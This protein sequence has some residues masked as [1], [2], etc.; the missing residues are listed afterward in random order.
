MA[1]TIL[2]NTLIRCISYI[3]KSEFILRMVK[4]QS[5]LFTR[6]FERI[7]YSHPND[8]HNH[9]Y[10]RRLRDAYSSIEIIQGMPDLTKHALLDPSEN[11]LVIIEDQIVEVGKSQEILA[12]FLRHSHHSL[13]SIGKQIIK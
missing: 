1:F 7:I 6:P 11:K 2:L 3:G 9:D 5:I 13:I 12:T 8:V 4:N 10:I